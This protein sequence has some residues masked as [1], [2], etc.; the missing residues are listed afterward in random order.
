MET[1]AKRVERDRMAQSV[2]AEAVGKLTYSETTKTV[3]VIAC[4]DAQ[5]QLV[6]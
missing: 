1:C 6:V 3:M 2:P 4:R 5:G